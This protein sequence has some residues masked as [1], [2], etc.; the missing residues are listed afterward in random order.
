M[1]AVNRSGVKRI[2]VV[3][4]AAI[5]LVGM[6]LLVVYLL[7]SREGARRE[8]CLHHQKQLAEALQGYEL[9]NSAFPGYV[10]RLEIGKEGEPLEV[11]WVVMI[12]RYL[13]EEDL[14]KTWE[15]GQQEIVYLP[16]LVCPADPP[17][18]EVRDSGP[19]SFV[20]NCGVADDSGEV[21][22]GVCGKYK[23]VSLDYIEQHDGAA[24]VLL[25]SE[26]IQAGYWTGTTIADVGMVAFQ[27]PGPCSGINQCIDAG[28]RPQQLK[29]AR[30]SSFHSGGVN[31]AFCDG[32]ARFINQDIDYPLYRRL[33]ESYDQRVLVPPSF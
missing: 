27:T 6:A 23:G 18:P 13:G 32:N 16:K 9:F 1:P 2:E 12:F 31:A 28:D 20:V 30:P 17:L 15:G 11:S 8:M 26:N 4:V 21:Q 29:Y 24:T 3:V 22:G 33:L 14:W 19:L 7:H 10:N 5:L 25:F